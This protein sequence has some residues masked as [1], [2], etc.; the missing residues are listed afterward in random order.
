MKIKISK[1]FK[2][3]I[4]YLLGLTNNQSFTRQPKSR[5]LVIDNLPNGAIKELDKFLVYLREK[6]NV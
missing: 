2:V 1:F 3:S 5:V 4:D 6:Y